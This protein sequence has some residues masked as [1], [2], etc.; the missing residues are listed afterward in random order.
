MQK[1]GLIVG[2][3]YPLHQGHL[4]MI[5]SA[6]LSV[7]TL[8]IFVCSETKRDYQLFQESA[9]TKPPSNKD[10]VQWV[11]LAL[12]DI[13][14]IHIHDFN[15]DGI[16]SY[17]NGWEAWSHRLK[18]T[19]LQKEIDPSIIFSS[20]PQDKDF[21]EVHF[22]TPVRLVDPPRDD[23]PVSA[24]KIRTTPFQYWT[25]IPT[26]IRP[27]FTKHIFI[28]E[29]IPYESTLLPSLT[30]LFNAVEI[31]HFEKIILIP[32]SSSHLSALIESYNI[33]NRSI[34]AI[35]GND[36]FITHF[37]EKMKTYQDNT[38]TENRKT[39]IL[40]LPSKHEHLSSMSQIDYFKQISSF[41]YHQLKE[42]AIN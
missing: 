42:P 11:E 16:P 1:V 39:R 33:N 24:T 23:F 8:H 13:P 15:E 7:E 32:V 9:F 36:H 40:E 25:F 31:L 22:N 29:A 18:E 38:L 5:L 12:A 21:Y 4:N 19:L 26:M 14:G 2:K 35:I 17:P 41:I 28:D 37:N 6:K 30:K 34:S 27:F 10:R 3:F 20:E